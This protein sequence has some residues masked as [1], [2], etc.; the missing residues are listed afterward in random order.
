MRP[1][2]PPHESAIERLTELLVRGLAGRAAVR[3]QSA[4]A[5]SD[6]SEPEPASEILS[7]ATAT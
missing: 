3:V 7:G 1:K 4:F 5:A 2:G 6:G